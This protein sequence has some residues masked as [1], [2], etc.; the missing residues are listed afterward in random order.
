[1]EWHGWWDVLVVVV[2]VVGNIIAVINEAFPLRIVTAAGGVKS[3]RR[4]WQFR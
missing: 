2:V 3:G 1:M 4:R